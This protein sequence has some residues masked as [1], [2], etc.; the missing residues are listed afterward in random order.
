SRLEGVNKIYQTNI[1]ISESTYKLV[2]ERFFC[3]ELDFL[4]VKGKLEPTRIYELIERSEV[5]ADLAWVQEYQAALQSYR[6]GEWEK[7]IR[8][9]SALAESPLQDKAS[10]VML[11][12]CH[13]LL[14]NPPQEWD[15]ILT[16]EVK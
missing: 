3:R 9:F 11:D 16:L 10:K 4:R 12:R 13:Y 15:G 8:Q 7:A 14:K 2:K 1:I 6:E 5:Q